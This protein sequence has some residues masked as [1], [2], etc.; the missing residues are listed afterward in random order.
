M[1]FIQLLLYPLTFLYTLATNFRNHLY[2]IGYTKSF[3]FEVFTINVGNLT[4]GGTGKTPHVE[5]LLRLLKNNF[6]ISTLSRGYGRKTKGFIL[7]DNNSSAKQIG[8]EPMQF[9]KKFYPEVQIAVGEERALAIPCILLEKP[10]IDLI[11]LDDAFQHRAVKPHLNILI[12]DYRRLFY[13]DFPFP[14][15]RLR[16]SRRG[17]KR[18]D[19]VVVSKCSEDMQEEE[20]QIIRSNIL[21]YS[22]TDVPIFFTKITYGNPHSVFQNT[23]PIDFKKDRNLQIVLISGIAQ[24]KVFENYVAGMGKVLNHFIFPDHHFYT[25]SDLKKVF[26]LYDSVKNDQIIILTTEKDYVKFYLEDEFRMAF[27]DRS[28]FYLPI[29]ITFLEDKDN[30][31]ALIQDKINLWQAQ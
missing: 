22:L 26:E 13:K 24:P 9:Y 8:D 5:Y 23:S 20:K 27:A 25:I 14:S 2:N 29:E 28:F 7:A 16:E 1:N 18:A 11:I 17:A 15:G 6:K 12:T 4:V 19:V 3:E 10:A 31:D 30:F 21:R